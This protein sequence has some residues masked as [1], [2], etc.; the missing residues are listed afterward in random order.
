MTAIMDGSGLHIINGIAE[1]DGH[2]TWMAI[3]DWYNLAS[4]SRLIIDHYRNKLET[5]GLDKGTEASTYV[6]DLFISCQK[7]E[8]KNEGNTSLQNET[9]QICTRFCVFWDT[10]CVSDT[11]RLC[12][13]CPCP[14]LSMLL[15]I[16]VDCV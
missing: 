16:P 2:V 15:N 5:L 3:Y 10:V 12:D 7:L 11:E 8:E 13:L 9:T 6:N 1:P 14:T 4:T